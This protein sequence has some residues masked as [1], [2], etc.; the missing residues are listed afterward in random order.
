MTNTEIKNL[1]REKITDLT[2]WYDTKDLRVKIYFAIAVLLLI[3][4]CIAYVTGMLGSAYESVKTY[5]QIHQ[6]QK[7]NEADGEQ[8]EQLQ[9]QVPAIKENISN[10]KIQA[11]EKEGEVNAAKTNYNAAVNAADNARIETDKAVTAA[12]T[13]EQTPYKNVSLEAAQQ[14]RCRAFPERC[15]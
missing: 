14:A 1:I 11:A 13:V 5:L 3:S 10:L 15:K 2:D 8:V 12:N 7:Q 9:N 4:V 6:L